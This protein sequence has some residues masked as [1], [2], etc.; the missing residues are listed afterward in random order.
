MD[1]MRVVDLGMVDMRV[2]DMGMIVAGV[3]ELVVGGLEVVDLVVEVMGE[4][5]LKEME[6]VDED[7]LMKVEAED[8]SM[9]VHARF[10]THHRQDSI[11]EFEI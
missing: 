3:V 2:V 10:G 1:D 9:N 11:I 4:D 5:C 8:C 7:Y 6:V